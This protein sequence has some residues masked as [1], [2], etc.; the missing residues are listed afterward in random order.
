MPDL[1]VLFV[2]DCG[3]DQSREIL[4]AESDERIGALFLKQNIGQ[5][6]AFLTG[7][8]HVA[9]SRAVLLDGD[10]QDRPES[11]PAL[12]KGLTRAE[13]AFGQ[14]QPPASP[15]SAFLK[16]LFRIASR[17]RLPARVGTNVA[18]G[19]QALKFLSEVRDP[20][21]HLVGLL[22]LCGLDIVAVPVDRDRPT[23]PSSYNLNRRILLGLRALRGSG[24]FPWLPLLI[25]PRSAVVTTK[26]GWLQG[27]EP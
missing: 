10:L 25:K 1:D 23:G 8:K 26:T 16:G 20:D 27:I 3:T 13:I 4:L 14:R 21:P 24:L 9:T 2:E 22:A 5:H 7:I 12:L 15:G 11:I 18:L 19:P 6:K 17:G